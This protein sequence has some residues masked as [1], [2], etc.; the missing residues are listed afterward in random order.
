MR[1]KTSKKTWMLTTMIFSL[2]LVLVVVLTA[3]AMKPPHM[4]KALEHLKKART[5]LQEAAHG[6]FK[7]HRA[8]ALRLVNEAIAEV[9]AGI[10]VVK[11]QQ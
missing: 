4:A 8:R 9:H 11:E 7:G 2:A 10:R 1:P 3:M 6:P 5:Q